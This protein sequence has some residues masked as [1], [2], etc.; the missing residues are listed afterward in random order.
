[1]DARIV[2]VGELVEHHA[3]ALP[4]HG[5]G[6]VARIFHAAALGRE[7]Q[8]RAERLHR[9]GTLHRQVFGHHQ[10]HPVALDR[11]R[12]RQR[13]AGIARRGLDER[14]TRLDLP[15]LLR[16]PDHGQRRAILHGTRRVVA[17]QLA[18]HDRA[19]LGVLPRA[20]ALQGDQRRAADRV[21]DGG[22]GGGRG[23]S[24]SPL[25]C[26]NPGL[27]SSRRPGGEIGRRRG[28]KIPRRKACRF[29]SGP[30]HHGCSAMVLA[31][32]PH[33]ISRVPY[34]A[35]LGTVSPTTS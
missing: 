30:G 14:V 20:D 3:L 22:I 31:R 32:F 16:A 23:G 33:S 7:D 28:L 27:P 21:F 17:L 24:H 25:L 19:A 26:H 2:R 1:M 5:L 29:D 13:D 11:R 6:Q 9:L 15:T 8:L 18:Q 10:H 12:H 4:H 35:R 34:S